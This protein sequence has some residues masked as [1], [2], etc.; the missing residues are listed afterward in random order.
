MPLH[1]AGEN[2]SDRP[3][4]ED[5]RPLRRLPPRRRLP[6]RAAARHQPH[7]PFPGRSLAGK[8]RE[9]G[10]AGAA[11]SAFY[12][13]GHAVA[14]HPAAD[15]R[16][17]REVRQGSVQPYRQPR[18]LLLLRASVYL[19]RP[20]KARQR[21]RRP[22]HGNKSLLRQDPGGPQR[23]CQDRLRPR[24]GENDGLYTP[25]LHRQLR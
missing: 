13:S 12:L 24:H 17:F 3:F 4:P 16:C 9:E 25:D 2:G 1:H 5:T 14:L 18:S 11:V 23:C 15:L 20:G 21:R 6:L 7:L 19:P 22:R 10:G 8:G